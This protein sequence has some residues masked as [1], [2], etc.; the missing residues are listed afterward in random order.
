MEKEGF[1]GVAETHIF[2]GHPIPIVDF[3]GYFLSEDQ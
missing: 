3:H 2:S 1:V